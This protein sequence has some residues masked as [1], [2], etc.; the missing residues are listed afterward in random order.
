VAYDSQFEEQRHSLHRRVVQTIERLYPDRL[1][2]RVAQ[3]AHHAI[4]ARM[5]DVAIRYSMQAGA[6]A[7]SRFANLEAVT[8]YE[9]ALAALEAVPENRGK[10]EIAIDI[11]CELRT[12]LYP[13]AEWGRIETYLREAEQIASTFDDGERLGWVSAYLASLY[14]T[15]GKS[16]PEARALATRAASLARAGRNKKLYV[17]AQYY[18]TWADYIAADYEGAE[19]ICR[20]L[21]AGLRGARARERFGVVIPAI[22][23]RAYCARAL[24]ERGEFAEAER[25]A[26]EAVRL[27]GEFDHAFSLAWSLL[28]L[29]HA[30]AASQKLEEAEAT[31]QHAL[32]QCQ[33]WQ[34]SSQVP[35]V[36]ARLG[37]VRVALGRIAE[38]AELLERAVQGYDKTGMEHFLSISIVQW[39]EACLAANQ[40]DKARSCAERA[41]DL[42][43]RRGER[44][45]ETW[46]LRL[47]GEIARAEGHDL[48]LA[49]NCFAEALKKALRLKMRPLAARCH[50]DLYSLNCQIGAAETARQHKSIADTLCTHLGLPPWP[51]SDRS[52][53][54]L[55]SVV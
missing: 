15:G 9:E 45:F 38:G 17:A 53:P 55:R 1:F 11:R 6:K 39:G 51:K 47:S 27:S 40:T 29:G 54:Q 16:A 49:Q 12:A 26:R 33:R 14:L 41:L 35:L 52:K 2:E 25:L 42:A 30:L 5:G 32:E 37:S 44:G 13:L 10:R 21:M 3:L 36:M 23:S 20:R 19:R 4:R 43:T 28:A 24:T 46:A 18:L 50:F 8:H 31:L 22:Q 34:I 7:L 48:D